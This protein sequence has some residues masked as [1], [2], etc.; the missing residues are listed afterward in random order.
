MACEDGRKV[1]PFGLLLILPP[2]TAGEPAWAIAMS[3][4]GPAVPDAALRELALA[5]SDLTAAH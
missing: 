4:R 3:Y 5:A 1:A 2:A